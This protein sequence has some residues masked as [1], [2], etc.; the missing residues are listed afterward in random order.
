MKKGKYF[1]LF[2]NCILS[3][4]SNSAVVCDLQRHKVLNIPGLLYDIL[5]YNE[6]NLISFE[7]LCN[8]YSQYNEGLKKYAAFLVKEEVGFFT[9]DPMAFPD[10]DWSFHKP[11]EISNAI[12][13]IE[14]FD[15]YKYKL[16]IDELL[17]DVKCLALEVRF[18]GAVKIEHINLII[19]WVR[20]SALRLLNIA[21]PYQANIG[22]TDM[23]QVIKEAKVVGKV[24]IYNAIQNYVYPATEDRE[25]E[26]KLL[27]TMESLD[28]DLTIE[29]AYNFIP[30]MDIYA[31]S[32]NYNVGLNGKVFLD[33]K[34]DIYN[35]PGHRKKFGK[36]RE[37]FLKDHLKEAATHFHWKVTKSQIKVCQDC[38]FR[39]ICVD[40]AEIVQE[41]NDYFKRAA[42]WAP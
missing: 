22:E 18:T 33:E 36:Y 34:L 6:Q 20:G 28:N 40:F 30:M 17:M 11:Y 42:E 35:Y 31:E 29:P 2:A 26:G 19:D 23:L 39:G 7:K 14:I 3:S 4:G 1:K 37:G 21:Y 16:L 13:D 41:E 9:N 24:L 5:K 12:I 10:I 32:M 8:H 15:E 27:Y 38:K 25:L